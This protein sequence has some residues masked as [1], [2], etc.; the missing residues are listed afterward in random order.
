MVSTRLLELQL[1]RLASIYS[2]MVDSCGTDCKPGG[3]NKATGGKAAPVTNKVGQVAGGTTK[4]V[5]SAASGAVGTAGGAAK[6]VGGTATGAV[7]NLAN[8][9]KQTGAAIRRGDIKGT[10]TG[11][12]SGTGQTVAGKLRDQ[13]RCKA[14]MCKN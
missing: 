13:R 2:A 12:A 6:N 5:G 8:T 11:L 10:A 1:V 4:T 9:G 7:G 3:V 14:W